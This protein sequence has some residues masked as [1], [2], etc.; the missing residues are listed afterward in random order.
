MA[1]AARGLACRRGERLVL[2]DLSFELAAGGALILRGPNGSG[3]ST[4]L[5]LI[6]T[7]LRPED[8]RLAWDGE[9]VFAD[10]EA[11]RR[12]LAFV[13]HADAV[14]ALLTVAENLAFWARL[15]GRAG[16]LDEAMRALAID[17]LA[18]VPAQRLSAGQRKRIALARPLL[19]EAPLWL[20][21]E[22]AVSLDEDG[23]ARIS[24]A[25]EA[26]RAAGGMAIVATHVGL[27][28]AQADVLDLGAG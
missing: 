6:A 14:K 19:G 5:R 8:G 9:D 28:L 13:G 10:V 21:D 7:L 11:Q 2:R 20:L 17:R 22:P 25:I 24:A 1:L 23:V 18:D 16:G 26:H 3:K 15:A 4:L 27:D 12:R